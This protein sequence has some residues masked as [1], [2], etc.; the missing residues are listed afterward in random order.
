M[1]LVLIIGHTMTAP[2]WVRDR[3]ATRIE[4]NLGGMQIEFGDIELVIHKGWRP[5]VRLQDL[6]LS[7]PDGRVL[8]R[9]ADLEATLSMQGVMQGQIQPKRVFLNGAF[10]KLIRKVDGSI[11]LTFGDTGAPLQQ[12]PDMAELLANLDGILQSQPLQSLR[13]VEMDALTM[14]YED[15]R[16]DRGWTVDGGRV[17]LARQEDQLDISARFSLLGGRDYASTID[18]NY[19]RQIGQLEAEFGFAVQDIEAHDIAVQAVALEWLQ[20]LRAPISGALRGG[21]DNTGAVG[22]FSA[23]LNIGAGVL[24]PTDQTEPIPFDGARTYFTYTP[25]SETL[26]FDEISLSSDWVTAQGEGTAFLGGVSSGKLTELV[27]QIQVRDMS[28][29]PNDL[30]PEALKIGL[31][32][33]D[34]KLQLNPFRLSLGQMR[35]TDGDSTLRL[36]GGLSATGQ[37]WDLSV[38]GQMDHLKPG[39]LVELWPARAAPKP[40]KWVQENLL[41]G[42]LF[43]LEFG[44]RKHPKKP[45]DIYA[46]FDFSDAT[47]R[48]LKTLPPVTGAS[49]Q[50]TLVDQRF[51]TTATAG[52]VQSENHGAVDLAGTAFIIPDITI[53]P[54]APGIVRAI[55]QGPVAAVLSLLNRPP[56]SVLK[57]TD[58]PVDL[59]SGLVQ[60]SGTLALPLRN[61]VD[62]TEMEFFVN[63]V[64]D[65]VESSVLVPDQVVT[66][67]QLDV[68]VDQT[69]VVL[70][71]PGK[72]GQ[73]PVDV[74]W[75]QK[76]GKGV[77]RSSRITGQIELSPL[78]LET[79]DL[80]LPDRSVSGLG[81]ADFTLDLMVN[82]PPR[83]RMDSALV[84]VGL[85][86]PALGWYK[87]KASSGTLTLNGALGDVPK[88]DELYLKAAGLEA[89]GSVTNRPEGGLDRAAFS[90]VRMGSW[91]NAPVDIVGRGEG[92]APDMV[93]QG[94]VLDVRTADFG[95][96]SGGSGQSAMGTIKVALDRLQVTDTIALTALTGTFNSVG[97]MNG[98]FSGNLNG[99]TPVT[100]DMVPNGA[101]S[102]FRIRSKDAG[103]VFRDAGLLTQARG[104]DFSMTLNPV[105]TASYLGTVRVTDTRVKDAPAIAALLNA[106][107]IVGLVDEMVGNGIYFSE[108]DGRFRI[109]PAKLTLYEGS[110]IGPSM[111]ITMDGNYDP[112]SKQLKMQGVVSP[113]YLLNGIGS[114]LTRKG[115]GV[116]GFNYYLSGPSDDPVV[117]VNPLSALAPVMLRDVF[118]NAPRDPSTRASP[119]SGRRRSPDLQDGSAGGR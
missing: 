28:V 104:G 105:E 23:T 44:L 57:D 12:A 66:A 64:V 93:I 21:I 109:D 106:V 71:G 76:L 108:V 59:A 55:A 17:V 113:V 53:K 110:A 29:N 41:A 102:A 25:T 37:G 15:L 112:N 116:I 39:R 4:Q 60:A 92:V 61:K 1:L 45:A 56:L 115:E 20:V 74:S 6:E 46:G 33:A 119:D 16:S 11:S 2:I 34:L 91:F 94:G 10:A 18:A 27:A 47:V 19:T 85:Q 42:N 26:V 72:I 78:L 88:I 90:S 100:G 111:G 38:D 80:G 5:R 13:L 97:G 30:Y 103:G 32:Q 50:A 35:V 24:Q 79:F 86:I 58:L 81:S 95:S 84:G 7:Q 43:D 101:R 117:Q 36:T 40:R 118:R 67:A 14:R 77:E 31:A 22:P 107:S 48:F 83:L 54:G 70:S 73:L 82:Q 75:R 96:D 52:Q 49:G 68:W 99:Q 62:F 51:V 69:E 89:T 9:L 3:I 65:G 63:G 8:L 114:V 98:V 87:S